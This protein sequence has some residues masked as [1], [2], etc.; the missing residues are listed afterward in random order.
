MLSDQ[1]CNGLREEIIDVNKIDDVRRLA[2]KGRALPRSSEE[3][4]SPSLRRGGAWRRW[5]LLGVA[6]SGKA[7]ESEYALV[8]LTTG[9]GDLPSQQQLHTSM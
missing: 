6:R 7:P 8:L 2:G 9:L 3:S 5:P 4:W 1:N